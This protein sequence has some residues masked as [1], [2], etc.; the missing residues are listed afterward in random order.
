MGTGRSSQQ[1]C[2]RSGL[3]G[4]CRPGLHNQGSSLHWKMPGHECWQSLPRAGNRGQQKK[5]RQHN[6]R[7]SSFWDYTK[8]EYDGRCQQMQGARYDSRNRCPNSGFWIPGNPKPK[9]HNPKA[10]SRLLTSG[11][12]WTSAG[13]K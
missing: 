1:P 5:T 12:G 10:L 7:E 13:V 11:S 2:R 3:V 4:S 6:M 9:T 8:L